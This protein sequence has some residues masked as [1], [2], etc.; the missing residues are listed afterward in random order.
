MLSKINKFVKLPIWTKKHHF[1][2]TKLL[3]KQPLVEPPKKGIV[4]FA[5]IA[6]NVEQ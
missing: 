3:S 2:A 5:M 6:F 4:H 1:E